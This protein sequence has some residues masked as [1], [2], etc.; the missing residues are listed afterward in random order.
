[1]SKYECILVNKFDFAYGLDKYPNAVTNTHFWMAN[2]FL[3]EPT[4]ITIDETNYIFLS[5]NALKKFGVF[6]TIFAQKIGVID[7]DF[8]LKN[9]RIQRG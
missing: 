2:S 1:M 4:V 5:F 7:T 6:N 9:M 3:N 8:L